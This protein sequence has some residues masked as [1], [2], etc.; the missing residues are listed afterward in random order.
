[1]FQGSREPW[2]SLSS[3][4]LSFSLSLYLSIYLS[5]SVQQM[6]NGGGYLLPVTTKPILAPGDPKQ[7]L[8]AEIEV[9]TFPRV[10]IYIGFA[11][12][13]YIACSVY[14]SS[15]ENKTHRDGVCTLT[16]HHLS[17]ANRGINAFFVG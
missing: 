14:T 7:G 2:D 12:L 5:L 6:K 1:M 8:E 17:W 13:V 16:T 11:L 3:R 15:S 4:A 9:L 10:S